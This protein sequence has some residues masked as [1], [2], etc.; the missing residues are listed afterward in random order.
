MGL[1]LETAAARRRALLAEQATGFAATALENLRREFPY[2]LS[3]LMR[4]PG[5][6]PQAPRDIHPAFHS[7]FDWHSC[8]EMHWV[9]VRLLRTLPGALDEAEIRGA[10][11]ANLTAAHLARQVTRVPEV[12]AFPVPDE[13]PVSLVEH[14]LRSAWANGDDA[15]NASIRVRAASEAVEGPTDVLAHAL[16]ALATA[17]VDLPAEP[18]DRWVRPPWVA[19][20]LAIDDYLRIPRAWP[21]RIGT[22]IAHDPR[23]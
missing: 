19:W 10:L 20:N 2:H 9:L 6:F 3:R 4:Q 22:S 8:V 18:A 13:R 16:E 11:A 17:R 5:D 7:S 14:Y 21:D 12:L 1:D 23:A 15:A